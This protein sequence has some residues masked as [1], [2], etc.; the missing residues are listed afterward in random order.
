MDAYKHR[1]LKSL[2]FSRSDPFPLTNPEVSQL[3]GIIGVQ[4]CAEVC[5][6]R[7]PRLAACPINV[8][9]FRRATHGA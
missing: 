3:S 5:P 8:I 1:E 7:P 4:I 6:L 2:D 9:F